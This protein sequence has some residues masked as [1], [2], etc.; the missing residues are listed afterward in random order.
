MPDDPIA[1]VFAKRP[2]DLA[3]QDIDRVIEYFRD[4]RAK[5]QIA[6][7]PAKAAKAPAPAKI[8]LEDLG[9]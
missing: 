8:N 4:A 5:G 7:K 2:E 1:A 6:G 9:M 3:R